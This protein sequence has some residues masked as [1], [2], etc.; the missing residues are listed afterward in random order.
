MRFL[1]FVILLF[2][3]ACGTPTAIQPVQLSASNVASMKAAVAGETRNPSSA[4]FRGLRT[5]RTANGDEV[6]C[7]EANGQ[8]GFGGY[9]G[10]E[11][12]YAR[13]RTGAI[14]V[15]ELNPQNASIACQQAASGTINLT[16]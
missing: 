3:A 6:L 2:I 9:T 11:T 4:T 12:F 10:F 1:P 15:L 16:G 13:F 5:Y 8:N 14:V 7:G